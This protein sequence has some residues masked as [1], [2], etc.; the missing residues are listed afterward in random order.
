MKFERTVAVYILNKD[1]KILMLNHKKLETW[2]PP[3]G[4]VE[5]NELMHE[6]AI[7][8]V[9]EE[10]GIKIEFIYD[11]SLF[12]E[13]EDDRV[14]LLPRPLFVEIEDIGDHYHEDFVYVARALDDNIINIENHEI[15][16]FHYNDALKLNIFHNVKKQLQYIK[17][18]IID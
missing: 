2:L 16:W 9:A 3:G 13:G 6:A 5:E 7:R 10:A 11:K 12:E 4:H 15:A 17:K 1:N 14:K 8:E 18:H